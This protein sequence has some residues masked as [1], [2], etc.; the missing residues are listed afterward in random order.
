MR[1]SRPAPERYAAALR[2]DAE[3]PKAPP[4]PETSPHRP[5]HP[6]G[7]MVGGAF[8]QAGYEAPEPVGLPA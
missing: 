5:L 7:F 2:A 6:I 1:S 4:V 3:A 8:F